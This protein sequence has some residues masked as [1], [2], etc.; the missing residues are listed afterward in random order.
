MY[1]RT[2]T[3]PRSI[4]TRTLLLLVTAAAVNADASLPDPTRPVTKAHSSAS[5]TAVADEVLTLQSVLIAGDRRLAIINGQRL[6]VGNTIGRSRVVRIEAGQVQVRRD[7]QLQTLT[8]YN[9]PAGFVR[10]QP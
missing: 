3:A 5:A 10:G 7:G 9:R 1:K 6:Q 2:K 8:V 4:L